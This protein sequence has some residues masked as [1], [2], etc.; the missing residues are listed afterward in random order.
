MR[1]S[2]VTMY[3]DN[4]KEIADI[5]V[6]VMK[7]Y[8]DKHRYSF[9]EIKLENGNEYHYKKHEY[10]KDLMATDVEV[11]FFLDVDA[12][13]T[14][15]SVPIENFLDEEHDFYITRDVT[16]LNGG[17]FILKNTYWGKVFNVYILSQRD[18][19]GNEQNVY[20]DCY[21]VFSFKIKVLEH[22]SINSYQYDIY[23]ELPDVR[24]E[25]EGHWHE[26]NFILHTPGAALSLRIE[27]LKNAKITL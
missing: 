8:C 18:N 4:Y 21:D 26:G 14:N 7:Q 25:S 24:K 13:I 10:F 17:V 12:L 5:T 2:V 16:E 20:N 11:I 15:L 27:T 1:V 23:P 3:A 22:P 19:Y 6:P 9:H